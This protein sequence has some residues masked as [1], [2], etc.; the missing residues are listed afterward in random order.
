MFVKIRQKLVD[1]NFCNEVCH[2][3]WIR[4]KFDANCSCY[5]LHLEFSVLQKPNETVK[6]ES[7]FVGLLYNIFTY[8]VRKANVGQKRL[9][10]L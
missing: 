9:L 8:V 3:L 7:L 1:N 10:V 5:K 4:Y 6:S 2:L